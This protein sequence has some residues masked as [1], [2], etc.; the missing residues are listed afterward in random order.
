MRRGVSLALAAAL[1]LSGCGA[2]PRP[3]EMGDMALL[4]V[5]GV[6]RGEGG[7]AMSAATGPQ[8][9]EQPA[10]LWR[11]EGSSLS[12]AAQAIQ[13]RSDRYVFFGYVDQL[14]LGEDQSR[15]GVEDIFAYVARDTQLSLAARLWVVQDGDAH[16]ALEAGGDQGVESRLAT[17]AADGEMGLS[18]R[19]R[20]VGEVYAQLLEQG[21][22]YAPALTVGEAEL[23][24]AGY[25]VFAGEHL[26]G[27]LEGESARGLEL[28]L[29]CPMAEVVEVPLPDSR[30]AVRITGAKTISRFGGPD[31][32]IKLTCR[33]TAE[34]AEGDGPLSEAER[35]T[36]CRHLE[37]LAERELASA[38]EQLRAWK[39]DCAG[40]GPRA[41][42]S[43]PGL[44]SKLEPDWPEVFSRLEPEL[45]V[46]A[47]LPGG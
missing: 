6:D 23:T 44:W 16:G 3:R 46:Q 8:P 35:E 42:L 32:E 18:I 21:C 11:G 15:R 47:D 43:D 25:A 4:R 38:L 14:L 5:M 10:R 12:A 22:S 27:F 9:P 36:V 39:A 20:R 34:L 40:L 28:L 26:A 33:V 30:A 1:F 2:L 19:P 45:I 41:A 17:L 7:P 29:G 13:S 24:A 37:T 31:G